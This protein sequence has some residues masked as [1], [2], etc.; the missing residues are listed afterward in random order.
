[1]AEALNTYNQTGIIFPFVLAD[2]KIVVSN[3]K[4][5]IKASILTIVHWP[6]TTMPFDPRFGSRIEELIGEQNTTVLAVLV[7]NFLYDALSYYERRIVV[8]DLTI[9]MPS[10]H[11]MH[12]LL[13][14]KILATSLVT[15]LEITRAV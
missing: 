6:I 8:L 2:G 3:Y 13:K 12:V 10:V 14:Y 5:L 1:M 15:E 11:S 4:D 7:R 9:T